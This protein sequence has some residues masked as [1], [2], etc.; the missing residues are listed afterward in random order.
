[1]ERKSARNLNVKKLPSIAMLQTN[2]NMFYFAEFRYLN[3]IQQ[4]KFET[5]K[6]M[7]ILP[8]KTRTNKVDINLLIFILL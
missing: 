4:Y 3:N 1:M 5:R 6:K 8:K 7:E 2:K